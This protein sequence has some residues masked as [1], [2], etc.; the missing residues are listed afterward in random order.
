VAFPAI[1][2]RIPPGLLSYFGLKTTGRN[3]AGFADALAPVVEMRDW[4]LASGVTGFA[5]LGTVGNTTAQLVAL[6]A[7]LIVPDGEWWYVHQA[8]A[9]YVTDNT[10]AVAQLAYAEVQVTWGGAATATVIRGPT[11]QTLPSVGGRYSLIAPDY[12]WWPPGTNMRVNITASAVVNPGGAAISG[13]AL[14]TRL[15]I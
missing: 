12:R 6:P 5:A 2:N 7:P 9:A 10:V 13:S 1:V 15:P 14:V 8:S 3:P 4:Y 11:V